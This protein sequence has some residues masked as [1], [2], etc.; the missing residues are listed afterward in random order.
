MKQ[1]KPSITTEVKVMLNTH[2][3]YELN[4]YDGRL[5]AKHKN[6]II[7][8]HSEGINRTLPIYFTEKVSFVPSF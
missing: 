7:R 6:E 8:Q 3:E 4:T 1:T 5:S 2:G